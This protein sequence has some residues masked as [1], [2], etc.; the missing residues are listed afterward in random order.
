MPQL[1]GRFAERCE[2]DENLEDKNN[3][4][5]GVVDRTLRNG[6]AKSAPIAE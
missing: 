3:K 4:C 2:S 1:H 5:R 6:H